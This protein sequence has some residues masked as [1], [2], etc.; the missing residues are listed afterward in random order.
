MP[1]PLLQASL[2]LLDLNIELADSRNLLAQGVDQ[3]PR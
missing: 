3:Q 2:N 1:M